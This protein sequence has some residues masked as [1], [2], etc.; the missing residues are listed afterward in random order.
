MHDDGH[1][2]NR[3][4]THLHAET[5]THTRTK[6]T[7]VRTGSHRCTGTQMQVHTNVPEHMCTHSRRYT[8][9]HGPTPGC[10][11]ETCSGRPKRER[12]ARCCLLSLLETRTSA[13]INGPC[14][15]QSKQPAFQPSP[16][17]GARGSL[18]HGEGRESPQRRPC[19]PKGLPGNAFP[20]PRRERRRERSQRSAYLPAHRSC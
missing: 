16:S 7:G 17:V 3:C 11:P 13:C 4:S 20:K 12:G 5:Q 15:D 10:K 6:D 18:K 2:L 8:H 9:I 19:P 14:S 1:K